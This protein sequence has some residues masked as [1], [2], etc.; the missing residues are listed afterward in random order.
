MKVANLLPYLK[1]I[2][3]LGLFLL[4]LDK[5]LTIAPRSICVPNS[6]LIESYLIQNSKYAIVQGFPVRCKRMMAVQL[7]CRLG[8]RSDEA[9]CYSVLVG[10]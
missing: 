5:Q 2:S 9:Q 4:I 6:D 10:W 1:N 3:V 7:C 8:K